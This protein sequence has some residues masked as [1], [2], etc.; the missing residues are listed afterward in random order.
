M[1][2]QTDASNVQGIILAGVHAWGESRLEEI[3][4]KPLL[5]ILGKPVVWYSLEW[6][7]RHHIRHATICG[8][9]DTAAFRHSLGDKKLA[10]V[11][12]NYCEDL[13]PRG[14]AGCMRDAAQSSSADTFVVVDGTIV[15]RVDLDDL[16][17]AHTR[18]GAALTVVVAKDSHGAEAE[19]TGIYVVSRSALEHI[20]AKGYQDIK[21]ML[22]PRLY[23]AGSRVLP[24][25]TA[26]EATLRVT[27]AAS[28]LNVLNWALQSPSKWPAAYHSAGTATVHVTSYVARS[29][30][31]V[32]DVVVGPDCAIEDGATILGPTVISPGSI[33]GRNAVVSRTSIW[34]DCRISAGAFIDRCILTSGS[35]I[36]ANQAV[37]D[38]VWMGTSPQGELPDTKDLYWAMAE[39]QEAIIDIK[40]DTL[41]ANLQPHM[42]SQVNLGIAAMA[43]RATLAEGIRM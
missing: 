26:A 20:P 9:S 14:P 38:T 5:P 13:M 41:F 7:G 19:P 4:C 32:G 27:N 29:A 31:L 18:S 2:M 39:P 17:A 10:G 1:V 16:L 33:I 35:R 37:R 30:R 22:I 3:C 21:E 42:G 36:D 12:L 34:S 28:Y 8:N 40:A 15:T 25:T 11:K 24:Y 43:A 6:M 23:E